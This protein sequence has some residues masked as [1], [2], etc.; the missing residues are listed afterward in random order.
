MTFDNRLVEC[1][2]E[3]VPTRYNSGRSARGSEAAYSLIGAMSHVSGSPTGSTETMSEAI[4]GLNFTNK[5][6][7]CDTPL[8]KQDGRNNENI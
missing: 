7:G 2:D 3:N 5:R 1:R 8:V 4:G 6:N